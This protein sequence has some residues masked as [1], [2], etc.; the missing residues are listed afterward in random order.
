MVVYLLLTLEDTVGYIA[1][2]RSHGMA[3][4]GLHAVTAEGATGRY[5]LRQ[6]GHGV[7]VMRE[8]GGDV[9]LEAAL[10]LVAV[11]ERQL[12]THIIHRAG[13]DPF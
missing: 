1:H 8:V 11:A 5:R 2:L 9:I 12:H 10:G 13:V 6:F 4:Y 7:L 3:D